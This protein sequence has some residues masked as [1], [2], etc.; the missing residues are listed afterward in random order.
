MGADGEA[1]RRP[2]PI[3]PGRVAVFTESGMVHDQR[4]ERKVLAALEAWGREQPLPPTLR[5][6]AR[7]SGLASTW[8]V[9]YHLRKLAAQGLVELRRKSARGVLARPRPRGI[10]L[11]DRVSAGRPVLAAE[12][13]DER[14]DTGALFPAADDIF[15]LRVKGDSMTGAGINDGD[16]VFIRR[17]PTANPGDIVAALI[18]DEALLKRFYKKKDGVHLVAEHPGFATLVTREA[19]ILGVLAGLVRCC[20][21]DGRKK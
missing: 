7:R 4:A 17:Q 5:E 6:L 9:R 19:R 1:S 3:L 10:P 21:A 12:G 15:A 2:P 13:H 11:L 14:V 16:L 18:G 20:R 8:T